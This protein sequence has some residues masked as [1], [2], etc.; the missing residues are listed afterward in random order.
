[1]K[2]SNTFLDLLIIMI[3]AVVIL[4]GVSQFYPISW[5]WILSPIWN[6]IFLILIE[7]ILVLF[8][9]LL[10]LIHQ[11]SKYYW[12]KITHGNKKNSKTNGE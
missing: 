3:V 10:I 1:M 2:K 9:T 5:I 12:E 11:F 6:V 4:W 8:K 7:I